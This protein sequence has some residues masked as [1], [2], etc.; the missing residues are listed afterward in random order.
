MPP[1]P[2]PNVRTDRSRAN[3][4]DAYGLRPLEHPWALLSPYEFMKFWRCVPLLIPNCYP[5]GRVRT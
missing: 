5:D 3:D 2:K 4:V 1:T